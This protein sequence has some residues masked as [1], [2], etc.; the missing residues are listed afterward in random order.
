MEGK[1]DYYILRY[2][3]TVCSASEL[4]LI[5][6]LGAGTF[7]ALAGLHVGWNLKFLFVLDGD[8]QG[9]VERKRY[10][11]EFG[12]PENRIAAISELL[13]GA[14]FIE[15][16]LDQDALDF[17]QKELSLAKH[18]SKSQ[19]RR[20]FQERLASDN[21]HKL[22]SGFASR[23]TTMMNALKSRL[24]YAREA[25]LVAVSEGEEIED[26]PATC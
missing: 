11:A 19:I 25:L 12:I 15:D 26:H 17:I 14:T 21:I 2:A 1:S 18:P 7:G 5:P 13:P 4:P 6:A 16:L 9:D 3:A 20:F 8:H 23:A 22:S 10:S 24:E